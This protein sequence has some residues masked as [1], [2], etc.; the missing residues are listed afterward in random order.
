MVSA[1][2]RLVAH[3]GSS[4]RLDRGTSAI[5]PPEIDPL[6]NRSLKSWLST[7]RTD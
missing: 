7:E 3:D 1:A 5:Q 6:F 4:L 2:A